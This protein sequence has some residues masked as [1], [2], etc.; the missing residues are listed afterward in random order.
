M[1]IIFVALFSY[2]STLSSNTAFAVNNDNIR[3]CHATGSSTNPYNSITVDES[4][5]DGLGNGNAD[6]NQDGH[7]NGEDIIPPGSW[8]L[9]GRNWTTQGQLI[10]GNNCADPGSPTATPTPTIA[11]NNPTPTPTPGII[12]CDGQC[13]CEVNCDPEPTV[14]PTP[15]IV[16]PT[17]ILPTIPEECPEW[18]NNCE[19]GNIN[20][21]PTQA[22][23][24]TPTPTV[25]PD[26][27]ST[28][29]PTDTPSNN[30]GTGG[31]SSSS[32]Q[33]TSASTSEGHVL[34]AATLPA[35]GSFMNSLM[36]A[37][38]ITGLGLVVL[39]QKK[40]APKKA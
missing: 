20:L 36:D 10:W 13:G 2:T 29:K 30:G 32:V 28:P 15:T 5:I 1:L 14:T 7:Q 27:T 12:L 22:C 4:S 11:Q 25:T 37:L 35:T 34:G 21:T 31:G 39:S 16:I 38:L 8:D 33:S 9:D 40:Y 18:A 24:T 17:V 19:I 23:C 3:I 6:H 26:P